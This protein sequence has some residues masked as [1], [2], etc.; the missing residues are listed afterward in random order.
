MN[1]DEALTLPQA[2][3]LIR[4]YQTHRR[5]FPWRHTRDPYR[6]WVS[7]IMLQQTRT[8]AVVPYYERFLKELPDVSALA[9]CEEDRL[10]RLWEGLGYYSRARNLQ[11]C[12]RILVTSCQGELPRSVAELK[13]LPG[14][15]SYTAGAIASFA[16]DQAVPAV[17]GNVLRV[18]SRLQ[19][20]REDI[21]DPHTRKNLEEALQRFL[22]EHAEALRET[23]PRFSAAF[24]QGLM[25]LGALLCLPH[26][27]PR[28]ADCPW[29]QSCLA[30]RNGLTDQ[31]PVR[32][33]GRKRKTEQRT[34]LVIRDGCRFFLQKR[35]DHGLLASLYEFVNLSG[36]L[37]QSE[38]V[39]AVETLGGQVMRIRRLPDAKH[40]F[41]HLEWQMIGYEV[42][43]ADTGT[44]P[45]ERGLLVTEKEL[46]SLAVPSAFAVYLKEY[47]LR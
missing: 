15:G 10:F 5:D 37:S 2:E 4:W 11:K 28:C 26:G 7:E 32:H 46:Q 9:A 21:A 41:T 39:K 36:H 18:L 17:D 47:D 22:T 27:T 33:A 19:A 14:I 6:I 8:E 30:H 43:I 29:R 31:I 16:F 23:D 35:P 40:V 13:K 34:V 45:R 44:L 3:A 25:D 12:A 20:S 1:P 42:M 24:N 38:A